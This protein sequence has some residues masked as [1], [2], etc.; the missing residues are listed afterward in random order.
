MSASALATTTYLIAPLT[1]VM[2]VLLLSEAP[3][4]AAYV[5]G[6]LTL[7][8]VAVAQTDRQVPAPAQGRLDP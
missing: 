1:I 8:G 3:P 4:G 7:V 6:V 5:G 2:S